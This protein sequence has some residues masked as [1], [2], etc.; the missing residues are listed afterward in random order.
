[1]SLEKRVRTLWLVWRLKWSMACSP[2]PKIFGEGR[3]AESC[4]N[5]SARISPVAV[6]KLGGREGEREGGR[7]GGRERGREGGG[8]DQRGGL[9]QTATEQ[10]E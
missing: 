4:R 10:G 1:M 2:R 9:T 8:T 6:E 5:W 3:R 7:E